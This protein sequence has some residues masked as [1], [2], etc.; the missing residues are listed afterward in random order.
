MCEAPSR[1]RQP[2]VPDCST[3]RT[4]ARCSS[5]R[6]AS[7]VGAQAKLL[8]VLQDGEVRRVGENQARRVDVRIIAATNVSSKRPCAA[9][10]FGPTCSTAS[11]SCACGCRRCA[12]AGRHPD[13]GRAL[14]ARLLA[15]GSDR[16]PR[17]IDACSRPSRGTTG[18]ATSANCRT[19]WQRSRCACRRADVSA[20]R[21]PWTSRASPRPARPRG[22]RRRVAS[23]RPARS[24]GPD[25]RRRPLVARRRDLGLTRQGLSKLVRRLGWTDEEGWRSVDYHSGR[26]CL[27]FL[28]CG[29]CCSPSPC[30]WG[31]R[32]W[33]LP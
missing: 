33:C 22:R 12:S 27:R 5:T 20:S 18:L 25:P 7:S 30:C 15:R 17:S 16:A 9:A 24:R 6:W 3:K 31:S 14:L 8:R 4:A 26:P 23:S 29:G 21:C 28:A 11:T 10:P 2:I 19:C 13:A 32:R 1:A